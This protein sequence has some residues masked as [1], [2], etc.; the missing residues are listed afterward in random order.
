MHIGMIA[1][2]RLDRAKDKIRACVVGCGRMGATI[3]DELPPPLHAWR[4]M[5][6]VAALRSLAE[7]DLVA[8][9]SRSA[10]RAE[11][12]RRRFG[13]PSCYTELARMLAAER[14]DLLCIATPPESHLAIIECAVAAGVRALYCEKPLGRTLGEV[15]RIVALVE[16]AG[17]HFHYGA[18]R[19]FMEPYRWAKQLVVS[20]AEGALVAVR[21]VNSPAPLYHIH[22]HSVDLLLYF[23]G[24]APLHV[25]AELERQS[26]P[27]PILLGATFHF[28]NGVRAEIA[29]GDGFEVALQ[30]GLST[31][32]IGDNGTR[33]EWRPPR[34]R[35]V[36]FSPVRSGVVA[37][38][39]E[40]LAALRQE[41]P[42][43]STLRSAQLG[44][45]VLAQLA[46]E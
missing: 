36:V 40:L 4:P 7:V 11:A 38:L 15:D 31:L 21:I 13:V 30:M 20:G 42:F 14:P 6:H 1:Y 2:Q 34:A 8:V 16:G 35:R 5:A 10:R 26:D 25:A 18:Q 43:C 12:V 45:Q 28:E 46:N 39:G 23:C 22:S 41:T 3:D 33:V 44:M 29:A 27:D 19:R 17:V 24:G 32:V 37:A 9:C